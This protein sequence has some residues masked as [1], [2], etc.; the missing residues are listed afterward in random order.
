MPSMF[1]APVENLITHFARLPGIGRKSAQRLAFYVLNWSQDE[2]G[3][4]SDAL[5]EAKRNIRFC[6]ICHN[7][8]DNEVCSVCSQDGRDASLICVVAES[9]DVAAIER[10]REFKGVYHVLHG[11]I[12]PLS[13]KSPDDIKIRELV[14]RVAAGGV[15]E[16]ILATNPDTEGDTTALYIARL[17]RPFSITVSRLAHGIPMG[18]HLEFADEITLLR[19]I[20]GRREI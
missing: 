10:T 7:L 19:A 2:V 3:A 5:I 12:S 4:F 14:S 6:Q 16:V 11:V 9:Q 8:T 17:L 13:M 1:P 20:E 18:G 15:R